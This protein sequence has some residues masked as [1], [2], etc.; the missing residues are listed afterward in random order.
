MHNL[1]TPLL[2]ATM[3]GALAGQQLVVPDSQNFFDSGTTTAGWPTAAAGGRVQ[4]CYDTSHFTLA[5]VT[6]PITINRLHFRAADGVPNPGGQMYAGVTVR[7]GYA[8]LD[9]A[10]LS[11]TYALNQGVMGPA[12]APLAITLLP[13][14]GTTPN[15]YFVNIDLAAN[16]AAFTYDPT[17]GN[18]LLVDLTF[19]SGPTPATFL[20][21]QATSSV[22]AQRGRRCAGTLAGPGALS[23][24]AAVIQLDFTGPGGYSVHNGA[25]VESY[26]ASCGVQA[27]SFYQAF[28]QEEFDLRGTPGNSM[29][30]VP[31]NSAAPNYY[32]VT[33]GN[34]A[35]D[36]SPKALG[37]GSPDIS[38]DGVVQETPGFTFYFPGGSTTTFSACTNG[39]CWLGSNTTGDFSPTLAEVLTS[40]PRFM[41]YWQDMHAGRNTLTNPGSGMYVYTDVSGGPGNRR[42]TVTWKEIGQFAGAATGGVAVNTFQLRMWENGNVEFRY[43]AM[44]S[45][46]SGGGFTGFSRGGSAASPAVDP[47]SRDLSAELPFVT[48]PEGTAGTASML[49]TVNSRPIMSLVAPVT[50][51]HTVSNLNPTTVAFAYLL[52][53]FGPEAPG[54]P[55]PF[56]NPGCLLS[57]TGDPWTMGASMPLPG[58][59]YADMGITLP[60]GASPNGFGLMGVSFYTQAVTLEYDGVWQLRSSNAL[61]HTLGLL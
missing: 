8:A 45:F 28:G 16:G 1:A 40:M 10:A 47:G 2:L 25:H 15:D 56:S 23:A 57:L 14:T 61:K 46:H 19:P 42:T 31:D 53:S 30:L 32:T 37:Y 43:G 52:L 34:Y 38:D 13:V 55:L 39:Y 54:L 41:P 20:S 26:G 49:L 44:S 6:G 58:A 27:Q 59:S 11:T 18:D 29:L 33:K 7:L 21:A 60:P 51:V 24:F 4:W 35:P 50:V 3:T 12:S 22:I 5:G 9:H 17:T 36:L 48:S